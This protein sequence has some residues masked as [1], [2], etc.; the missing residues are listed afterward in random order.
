MI[1]NRFIIETIN[2]QLKNITQIEHSHHRS[3]HGFMLNSLGGFTYCLK[4]K[5]SS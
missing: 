3:L 4:P 5:K 2:D 1:A